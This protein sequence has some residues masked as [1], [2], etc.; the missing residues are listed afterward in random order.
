M[1]V[2]L[3]H[4]ESPDDSLSA[5]VTSPRV[6]SLL[7]AATSIPVKS[8]KRERYVWR[9]FMKRARSWAAVCSC[10]APAARRLAA[11]AL[12][13]PQ[14]S[15]AFSLNATDTL[16][17]DRSR[18]TF[19]LLVATTSPMLAASNGRSAMYEVRP[20]RCDRPCTAMA[21]ADVAI[22]LSR[23][24]LESRRASSLSTSARSA[25]GR[26]RAPC[27]TSGTPARLQ[28]D[29]NSAKSCEFPCHTDPMKCTLALPLVEG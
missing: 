29:T 25:D 11:C 26:G 3:H 7:E 12:A 23:S 17:S 21:K 18:P 1:L 6:D 16:K 5:A 22:K 24:A 28:P 9:S 13:V 14:S 8:A 27:R 10:C 19:S 2:A 15:D 4:G 20:R